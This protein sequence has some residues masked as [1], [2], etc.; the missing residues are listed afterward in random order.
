[1]EFI[2]REMSSKPGTIYVRYDCAC[3]CKPGVEHRRG[4]SEVEHEQCCCGNVHFVGPEARQE[5]EKYIEGR[6]AED[7]ELGGYAVSEEQL[8]TPWGGSVTV[9]YAI[10][11]KPRAH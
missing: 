4:S 2:V 5:L 11:A 8:S 1:V 7:E 9:A 10:L 6:R 3:G